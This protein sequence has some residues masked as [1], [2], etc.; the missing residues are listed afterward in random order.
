MSPNRFLTPLTHKPPF[1]R[2]L[3]SFGAGQ[4]TWLGLKAASQLRDSAGFPPDFA[5][6][7]PTGRYVARHA[8]AYVIGR[9]RINTNKTEPP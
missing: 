2:G 9:T 4:A 3:S 7:T 5:A 8:G 1:L 6:A